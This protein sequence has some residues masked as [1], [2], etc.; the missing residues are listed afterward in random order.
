MQIVAIDRVGKREYR[1]SIAP[2]RSESGAGRRGGCR[3]TTTSKLKPGISIRAFESVDKAVEREHVSKQPGFI[4][5]E[6][7]HGADN[8]WLV[9]VHWRSVKDADASMATFQRA[10]AAGQFMSMIDASTMS[11][12]RY[13]K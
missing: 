6:S 11:M 10:S 12:K 8:E 13:Q 2:M 4:S 3:E 5:R 1:H 9:V 7:A